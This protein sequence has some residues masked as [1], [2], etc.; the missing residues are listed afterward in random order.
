MNISCQVTVASGLYVGTAAA[1]AVPVGG[2]AARGSLGTHRY[3]CG[4]H[5]GRGATDGCCL[6]EGDSVLLGSRY[7]GWKLSR[8]LVMSCR[9]LIL[10]MPVRKEWG[11]LRFH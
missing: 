3:H 7:G 2:H 9:M 5:T 6:Q 4:W 11:T 1:P 10:A 8:K